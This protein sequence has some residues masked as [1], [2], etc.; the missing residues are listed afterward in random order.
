MLAQRFELARSPTP[1]LEHLTWGFNKVLNSVRAMKTCILGSADE[2]VDTMT[3][4]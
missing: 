3:Q 4:F 1:V 2:V